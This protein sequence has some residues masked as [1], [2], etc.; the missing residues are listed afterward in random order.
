MNLINPRLLVQFSFF[1]MFMPSLLFA[2]HEQLQQL[3]KAIEECHEFKVEQFLSKLGNSLPKSDTIYAAFLGLKAKYYFNC[4]RDY[5]KAIEINK[6]AIALWKKTGIAATESFNQLLLNASAYAR[7]NGDKKA[8]Q[9]WLEKGLKNQ[10]ALGNSGAVLLTEFY[11]RKGILYRDNSEHT[12]ALEQFRQAARITEQIPGTRG[13]IAQV[14]ALTS[15]GAA[16]ARKGDSKQ[17]LG[18]LQNALRLLNGFVDKKEQEDLR[19]G[20]YNAIGAIYFQEQNFQKAIEYFELFLTSTASSDLINL[21]AASSNIAICH[22]YLGAPNKASDYFQKAIAYNEQFFGKH[23]PQLA[24][25]YANFALF[26]QFNGNLEEALQLNIRSLSANTRDFDFSDKEI[27]L[28]DLVKKQEFADPVNANGALNN[29]AHILWL[30]YQQSN[31]LEYLQRAHQIILAQVFLIDK[32]KNAFRSDEDKLNLFAQFHL[33]YAKG[34]IIADALY[35]QTKDK[36]Y[37]QE[38][39]GF[40]ERNKSVIL[41]AAMRSKEALNVAGIPA[42]IAQQQQ[43]LQ[44]NISRLERQRIEAT[45][46][47]E[48]SEVKSIEALL[49]DLNK[50]KEQL[51]QKLEKEYPKYHRLKYQEKV[52]TI[53][54]LQA[55]LDDN[56]LLLEYFIRDTVAYLFDISKTDYGLRALKFNAQS[57]K[58]IIAYHALL[59]DFSQV[60]TA[61]QAYHT[62]F[63]NLGH[64]LYNDYIEPIADKIKDKKQLIIIPDDVLSFIPFE[65]LLKGN[66]VAEANSYKD[67]PYLLKQYAINYN[68]AATLMTEQSIYTNNRQATAGLLALAATYNPRKDT[69]LSSKRSNRSR[70][71]RGVLQDLPAARSEVQDLHQRFGGYTEGAATEAQFKQIAMN[72]RIIHLAMHGVLD[73]ESPMLSGLVFTEDGNT[74]EDNILFAY[75]IAN[76]NLQAELVVLSA[77]ETGLGK[78]RHGE[79]MMSLARPFMYAGVPSLVLSLWQVNDASTALLMQEFYTNLDKG[80]DKATALQAAKLTY[81]ASVDNIAAHPAF[82]AAFIQLGDNSPIGIRA[83]ETPNYIWLLIV[84]SVLVLAVLF[85]IFRKRPKK[86]A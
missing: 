32:I 74:D 14:K 47:K 6:S 22:Y 35:Q 24:L 58:D 63:L 4:Q 46:R 9:D 5:P 2:Q 75:E 19:S 8:A 3:D 65:A 25:S 83:A 51:I 52:A 15:I 78:F 76:M 7:R 64:R 67:Y 18:Y 39:F 11:I 61:D 36:K 55:K 16:I 31:K 54:Q 42:E 23:H 84:L 79:G 70:S 28:L 44:K 40:A 80:W 53:E 30:L 26:K 62:R 69:S 37:I 41:A 60:A 85:F 45:R 12:L 27:D 29:Q 81:L 66:V 56:T 43:A 10:E 17:G 1:L 73:E 20:V 38:A 77:C 71:L 59:S 57:A 72:H 34:I 33:P 50:Q 48:T 13:K 86:A 21:A 68:Y 49:F 82:W